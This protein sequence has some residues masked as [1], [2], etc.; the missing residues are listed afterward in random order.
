MTEVVDDLAA[1]LW[2]GR[3]R[4]I[5]ILAHGITNSN[6][7]VDL[8]DERVVVRV[9]GNDT[10]LLGIDRSNEIVAGGLAAAIGVGPEVLATDEAT[11]CIVF[12]FIDGRPISASEL[13]E[14]PML[15]EFAETLRLVHHAGTAPTI[16][17]P[18][19]V[20][21]DHRDVAKVR[22]VEAPF[23]AVI[24]FEVLAR[25]ETARP[26][27][28]RVLGHNDLLNA[29]FLFD[30]RL[31]IVDWEYAGMSDPFF[32]LANVSV[33]NGFPVDAEITLLRHYFGDVS[34]PV[35][36]TL[37]VMQIVS[38]LREAMWG[39][40]QMAISSLEVDFTTYARDRG[41]H[42]LVLARD[43]DLDEHLDLARLYCQSES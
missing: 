20:I 7:V 2:P 11:G 37:H 32:D 9:P 5:E 42:A 15:R 6:Y 8:G 29:N 24:A 39:V 22:S 13:S 28:P 1:R 31:R 21:R 33:N 14:E 36:S 3:V 34:E 27:R 43:G 25:I 30:D 40:V 4:S 38:E 10:H 16:W 26:F 35:T 19:E 23:E 17:N 18:Y 12:R 41:E